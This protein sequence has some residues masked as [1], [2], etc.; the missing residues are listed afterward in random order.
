M[1]ARH[2]ITLGLSVLLLAAGCK[3][4]GPGAADGGGEMTIVVSSDAHLKKKEAQLATQRQHLEGERSR[5]L[6]EREKLISQIQGGA[7]TKTLVKL[8]QTLLA[9]EKRLAA[10]QDALDQQRAEVARQR[11]ALVGQAAPQDRAASLPA[12]EAAVA[13]READV[14]AR[15]KDVAARE[16]AVAR[17]EAR[18]AVREQALAV[19]ESLPPLVAPG[20]GGGGQTAT[21]AQVE[22]AHRAFRQLMVKRG[23]L[24]GDLPPDVAA[25]ERRFY[26]LSRKG[27]WSEALDT[28]H[29]LTQ[30]VKDVQVNEHFIQAKMA[31]LNALR[32]GRKL[33]GAQ[34]KQVESLLAQ[35]TSAFADGRQSDANL[36]L[37]RMFALLG[38]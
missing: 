30:A 38:K 3:G 20:G 33:S 13:R 18:L 8:Q 22:K 28:A 9:R 24:P 4:G 10:E 17:R 26:V 36:Q 11:D 31:R 23:I 37:N 1:Q 27:R 21:R 5:L 2:G 15:E 7:D 14:S 34:S 32:A 35:A 25:M 12:R 19:Q 16:K 29:D 6:A